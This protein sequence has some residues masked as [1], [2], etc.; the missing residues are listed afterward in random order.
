MK[1]NPLVLC[2]FL[3]IGISLQ[4]ADAG[5]I[6]EA[7][8]I[9]AKGTDVSVMAELTISGDY[10]TIVLTNTSPVDSLNPDDTLSSF[11]FDIVN[12]DGDRPAVAFTGA[13]GDVYLGSKTNPDQ[14]VEADADIMAVNMGDNSWLFA[15]MDKTADPY[16]GF[17][18]GTVGNSGLSPNNFSG[19]IVG[20][21]D[22][23]IYKGEITTQNLNGKLLVRETAAFTFTGLTGFTEDDIAPAFAFGLGTR[24][25]GLLTPEPATLAMLGL[26]A[27]LLRKRK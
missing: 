21:L 27:L 9:S 15:T 13:S 5:V 26:G 3:V 2:V 14:L 18:I 4:T 22:Y 12:G 10:L 7:S 1:R 8:G 11:Y 17:G 23:S 20:G 16:L 25:D 19:S 24:P 6:F